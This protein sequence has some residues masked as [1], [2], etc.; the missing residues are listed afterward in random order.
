MAK[1]VSKAAIRN[2]QWTASL[3]QPTNY[4]I[5]GFFSNNMATYKQK[6][7]TTTQLNIKMDPES[8]LQDLQDIYYGILGNRLSCEAK[9]QG[10]EVNRV[11][12]NKAT[13][14]A[15]DSGL[16]EPDI[17]AVTKTGELFFDKSFFSASTDSKRLLYSVGNSS[18][19]LWNAIYAPVTRKN[20]V[21]NLEEISGNYFQRKRLLKSFRSQITTKR[22]PS[23]NTKTLSLRIQTSR[24]R[25]SIG[26]KGKFHRKVLGH[27]LHSIETNKAINA[28][29]KEADLVF[30]ANPEKTLS[31]LNQINRLRI[32]TLGIIN[33]GSNLAFPFRSV[34]GSSLLATKPTINYPIIGNSNSLNFLRVVLTKFACVLN[35]K[36]A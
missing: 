1:L 32:P 17:W 8:Q 29:L 28:W 7:S 36:R 4:W 27:C 20:M 26:R 11:I 18:A 3:A 21:D 14:S 24:L 19:G 13:N 10:G 31:L 22:K 5:G 30:F 34:K 12:G 2:S 9:N 15:A 16:A 35:I 23:K 33:S 25:K 6:L